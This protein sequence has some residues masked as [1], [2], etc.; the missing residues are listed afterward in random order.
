[1]GALGF[2]YP[3]KVKNFLESIGIQDKITFDRSHYQIIT[4]YFDSVCSRPFDEFKENLKR[5]F[6]KEKRIDAFF[7]EFKGII[8]LAENIS[9]WHPD[10]LGPLWKMDSQK[11]ADPDLK[12]KMRLVERYARMP[13]ADLLGR[14]FSDPV[15]INFL[16]SQGTQEPTMSTLNLA[17]MWNIMSNEGIWFPSCGVHG[18]TDLM[19]KA[20]RKNGGNIKTGHPVE[21]IRIAGGKARGVL[22]RNGEKFDADWVVCNTDYK[23]T[24]LTLIEKTAL[25]SRY[26]KVLEEIPY[27]QSELCVY[28]GLNPEKVNWEAMKATHLFFR[29]RYDPGAAPSL[30][31][32]PNREI[33]ICLWS[34]K[35]P[36]LIPPGKTALVLRVGFPYDHFAH[37]RTGDKQ[38]KEDYKSF[39]E[40]LASSL[41]RTAENIL[42][43]L[44][45]AVEVM[46]VATP[47]TYQDWGQRH[48]GSLA[49]WTWKV[50]NAMSL[51]GKILVETPVPNM[52]MAGIYAATEL[53]LGGI[54][55]AMY[56]GNLAADLI[57]KREISNIKNL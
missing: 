3:G 26:L 29:H 8:G 54:P 56:T 35:V 18:L 16:G 53:F 32:F 40:K 37:F 22:C 5:I 33:E 52:L 1:M 34:D 9:S 31:D 21:K 55:T 12:S 49:G 57:L 43:G 38:R 46:E 27:T 6:S 19:A 23:K 11:K 36:G 42:P 30:E 25:T 13:S 44:R 51:G 15:L 41:V 10:Y 4:P 7:T 17:L 20:F 45:E 28:L 14:Y 48:F 50:K 47:L 24:F 2:S 39:K